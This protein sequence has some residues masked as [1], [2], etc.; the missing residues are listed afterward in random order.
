MTWNMKETLEKHTSKLEEHAPDPIVKSGYHHGDLR[1]GLIEATRRLVEERG[2]HGF[3]VSDACRLAG[4]STAAPYKHFKDK[5][6]MIVATVLEGMTR[7]RSNMLESIKEIP[8]GSPMRLKALGREYINFALKEPGIF[9]LKFGGFTDK[10]E[11]DRLQSYGEDTFGFVLQ[12][13][14]K[15]I[16]ETEINQDVRDRGF[17]LWSFVHGL[18]F[19]LYDKRLSDMGGGFDLDN[20]LSETAKMV[21]S[22]EK[23]RNL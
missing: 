5:N 14:A 12:E 15:C 11:D 3:S 13:V 10:L 18:S 22:T 16:G 4:V 9:R 7:H 8:E 2:Q 23:K 20:M 17:M 21:L 19:L 1:A 6:E